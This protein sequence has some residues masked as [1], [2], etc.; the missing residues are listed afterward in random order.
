MRLQVEEHGGEVYIEVNGVAGRHECVLRA[1]TVCSKAEC[2]PGDRASLLPQDVSVRAG[3]DNIRIRL[4][5]RG[6][7][8]LEALTVYRCMRH[9]L[10]EEGVLTRPA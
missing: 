10:I 6:D 8:R 5:R 7:L 9:A 1:L 4:R 3:S 2:G